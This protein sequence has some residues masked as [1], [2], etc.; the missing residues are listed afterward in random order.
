MFAPP[1]QL[2]FLIEMDPT[3]RAAMF[4]SP[5]QLLGVAV[6]PIVAS[7]TVTEQHFAGAGRTSASL[8]A[9]SF[10][11]ALFARQIRRPG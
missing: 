8:F 11:L 1:F 5:A 2:P 9:L 10:S 4:V 6:G 3:H 7:W